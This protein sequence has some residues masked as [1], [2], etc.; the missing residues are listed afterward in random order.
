VREVPPPPSDEAS[1]A[2][3]AAEPLQAPDAGQAGG[4]PLAGTAPPLAEPF[5]YPD[6]GYAEI[7]EGVD[8]NYGSR[9]EAELAP[10]KPSEAP[11]GDRQ[12]AQEEPS[13]ETRT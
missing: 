9:K 2:T 8:P 6:L 7:R 10:A 11:N 3:A 5:V 1:K 13:R 4:V 12:N